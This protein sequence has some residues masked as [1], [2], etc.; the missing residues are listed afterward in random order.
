MRNS[1]NDAFAGELRNR[2]TVRS[3][4]GLKIPC[5]DERRAGSSPAPGTFQNLSRVAKAQTVRASS[6]SG[7]PIRFRLYTRRSVG[8]DVVR[9]SGN[10]PGLEAP[11][12]DARLSA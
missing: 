12:G 6:A 5:R 3:G 8:A 7:Y 10:S 11:A 9:A 2:V 1:S 4:G